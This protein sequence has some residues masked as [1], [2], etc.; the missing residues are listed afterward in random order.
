M[1]S[2]SGPPQSFG[3][4]PQITHALQQQGYIAGHDVALSIHLSVVL[5]K[6][7]LIEGAAGVGKT[8]VAKVM[9]RALDTDLIR[10]QCYEGLDVHTALYEWNYQR[11]MLRI[12]LEEASDRP[13]EEKEHLI[14]S[15]PFMLKR[16]LL[17][18]ITADR[19]PVL[20]IDEIDRA[21]EEFEAFLL[22]VLS[23]FQVSIP[24]IGTIRAR[25]I[26][27]VVLTSNRTRDL[28]D[29]LRRRCLYVWI[30][31]PSF[32]KELAI[33]H[34]K[35]PEINDRLANQ[36]GAFMQLVRRVP[37]DKIP[38]IAETL[39]WSAALL[40]LHRDHLDPTAVEETLGC[41]C[42]DQEDLTRVRTQYLRPILD[43][44]DVVGQSDDGWN[45]ERIASL[46]AQLPKGR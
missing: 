19:A 30:D 16:P 3:G 32:D 39:D 28:S 38:G 26:P 44:I 12:K 6:P 4:I 42:K 17:Q 18:A 27:H 37:L 43:S 31:Y 5:R 45:A 24:E 15:E 7:L 9:A 1:G 21:D 11:Q 36:I 22:E 35:V 41:L 23:D 40:A 8:E 34:R 29:A 20:L 25:H 14:F 33:I 10:L 13:A 46:A 2:A